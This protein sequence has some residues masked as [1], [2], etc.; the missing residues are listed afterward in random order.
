[1]DW[2]QMA[3]H[4]CLMYLGDLCKNLNSLFSVRGSG[5]GRK[6]LHLLVPPFRCWESRG[7]FGRCDSSLQSLDVSFFSL[8]FR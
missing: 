3:C 5:T 6:L 2:A 7:T 4:R 8:P 1:M